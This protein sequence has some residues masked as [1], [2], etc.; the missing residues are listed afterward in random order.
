MEA[1][2]NE[3]ER[4]DKVV[5]YTEKLGIWHTI[6]LRLNIITLFFRLDMKSLVIL[7]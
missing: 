2:G 4:D 3:I 5:K 6:F 1:G 7:V